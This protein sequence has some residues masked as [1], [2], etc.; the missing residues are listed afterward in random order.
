MPTKKLDAVMRWMTYFGW[1]DGG[2][3]GSVKRDVDGK[4]IGRHNDYIWDQDVADAVRRRDLEIP[5]A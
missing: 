4:V 3:P 5:A 2:A 1:T